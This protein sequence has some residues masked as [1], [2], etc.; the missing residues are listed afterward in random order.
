M[1]VAI[2]ADPIYPVP[3]RAYGGTERMIFYLIKGLLEAGHEPVLF[4]PGDSKV[5][6]EVVPIVKKSIGYPKTLAGL[7]AHKLRVQSVKQHTRKLL[8]KRL[9]SFDIIHSEGFDLRA[10]KNFPNVTTLNGPIIFSD[11]KYYLAR[12]DLYYVSISKNQQRALPQLKYAGVVYNGEDPA[13]FPVIEK[14]QNYLCFIGRFDSDKNPHLAIQLAINLGMKIKLAG[15]IDFYGNTYFKEEVEPF[16]NHPL[17]EFLGELDS[18]DRTELVANARCNLHPTGFREPF[19]LT[20]M[21]AAYCGTPTLAIERGS[22]PELIREG[23]TGMLVE[24]FVE[25][26]SQIEA[27]FKMDRKYIARRTRRHFNYRRMA[28]GYIKAYKKVIREFDKHHK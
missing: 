28:E 19:G 3:P 15:K 12:R 9:K 5:D 8:R 2:V 26:Y 27:C 23:K 14:P 21:E 7:P 11:L 13:E 18:A 4:G 16:L 17:V 24:D 6:C 25:G 20:I 10:F 1:K 22:M